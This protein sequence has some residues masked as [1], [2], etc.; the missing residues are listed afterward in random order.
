MGMSFLEKLKGGQKE[1]KK[2]KEEKKPTLTP[3]EKL[4]PPQ[5]KRGE[6][7]GQLALD[8]YETEADFV[9]QSTIAGVK[10]KD[11]EISIEKDIVIIRGNRPQPKTEEEKK[12]L[13]QE[14]YWGPFSRK[15]I[16]PSEVDESRAKATMK[17][18]LLTLRIPKIK[19]HK[20]TKIIIEEEEK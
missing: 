7:E 19:P 3:K 4:K 17:D 8:V 11:L 14:C 2:L 12:Y 6:A 20:R 5:I 10:A 18:G 16:L 9:I 13:Y 1:E 15:L